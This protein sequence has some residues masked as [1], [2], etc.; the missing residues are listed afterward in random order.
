LLIRK[1]FVF[2]PN[3]CFKVSSAHLAKKHIVAKIRENKGKVKKKIKN[4]TCYS[5]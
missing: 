1:E 2:N 4:T 5:T 3:S